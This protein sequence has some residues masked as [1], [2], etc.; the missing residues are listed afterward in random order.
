[1]RERRSAFQLGVTY[2]TP[3]DLLRRVPPAVAQIIEAQS[4]ARFDRCHLIT[5]NDSSL[6]FE[7]VYFVLA[8]DF[9]LYADTQQAVLLAILECFRSLGV[10][11]ATPPL[12]PMPTRGGAGGVGVAAP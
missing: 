3:P 2:D 8:P 12:A 11:F 7:I 6:R 4:H 1:M 5:A 9:R 10:Q